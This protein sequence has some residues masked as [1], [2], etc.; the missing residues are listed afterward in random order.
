MFWMSLVWCND[1]FV[2]RLKINTTLAQSRSLYQNPILILSLTLRDLYTLIGVR[3]PNPNLLYFGRKTLRVACGRNR[4]DSDQ[5]YSRLDFL[6]N[7]NVARTPG[8]HCIMMDLIKFSHCSISADSFTSNGLLFRSSTGEYIYY[9]S[10]SS[11]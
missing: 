3:N 6:C 8:I 5:G 1:I 9:F 10:R 7:K 2:A 4:A 11:R